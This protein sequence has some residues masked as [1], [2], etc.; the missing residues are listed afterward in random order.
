MRANPSIILYFFI[1][2]MF[3]TIISL[4]QL[5]NFNLSPPYFIFICF[6]N[7]VFIASFIPS[8]RI[9]F[10]LFIVP[11][12]LP[13]L[14]CTFLPSSL[15]LRHFYLYPLHLL[16]SL[17]IPSFSLIPTSLYFFVSPCFFPFISPYK[18]FLSSS[19]LTSSLPLLFLS[20]SL[21]HYIFA[22][23]YYN[24]GAPF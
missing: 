21:S 5:P 19:H 3:A 2:F 15:H 13:H 8:T 23:H 22:S 1:F 7:W 18:L 20:L 4:Y 11:S 16:L 9:F 24:L 6:F 12:S 14:L 10:L 17:L